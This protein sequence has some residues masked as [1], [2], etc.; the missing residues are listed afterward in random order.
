MAEVDDAPAFTVYDKD[1]GTYVDMTTGLPVLIPSAPKIEGHESSPQ[2][3]DSGVFLEGDE[4]ALP[5]TPSP[6]RPTSTTPSFTS[7]TSSTSPTATQGLSRTDSK[8]TS[9]R[10]H[11][12]AALNLS[13]SRPPFEKPKSE[14][15]QRYALIRNSQTQS[16]AALKSPTQLLKNRLNLTPSKEKAEKLRVFTPPQ[17]M[18]NGCILP[19][20]AAQMTAFLGSNVRARTEKG[21]RP[22]WWC[23]FDR[24]VIFDGVVEGGT[25]E[26]DKYEGM[27]FVTRSSKGL[28]VARRRGDTEAVLI[29]LDCEHCQSMLRRTEWKYDVQVCKR[30][31]CWECRERCRWELED[32]IHAFESKEK[33]ETREKANEPKGYTAKPEDRDK[34]KRVRADS[35]LQDQQSREEELIAKVGIDASPQSPI[36]AMSSIEE[37]L[38]TA[39][40]VDIANEAAQEVN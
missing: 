7:S 26:A 1:T 23:K 37:R 21:G 8:T 13:N 38:G 36:E 32:S 27:K 28:S 12:P 6:S 19:G 40:E 5:P 31:V 10:L 24:L 35:V 11:R 29:P 2:D 30:G 3:R 39:F 33:E 9:R 4:E 34:A 17:S 22:A 18:L 14:L 15:E 25:G 20:P 16:K